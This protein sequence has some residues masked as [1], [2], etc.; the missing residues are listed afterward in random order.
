MDWRR[1]GVIVIR[2]PLLCEGLGSVKAE[3]TST[4][5]TCGA[6]VPAGI[7][8]CPVCALHRAGGNDSALKEAITAGPDSE[9]YSSDTEVGLAR[10]LRSPV[11]P[12]EGGSEARSTT[13]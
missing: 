6:R 10:V 8:F 13:R 3:G 2:E 9:H 11:R 12:D 1:R 7:D 4:C 5:Q